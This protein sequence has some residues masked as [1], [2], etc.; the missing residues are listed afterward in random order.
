MKYGMFKIGNNKITHIELVFGTEI[1][2]RKL[3]L[4]NNSNYNAENCFVMISSTL[5]CLRKMVSH[6]SPYKSY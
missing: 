1:I 6:H 5:L 2:L 3:L 4:K